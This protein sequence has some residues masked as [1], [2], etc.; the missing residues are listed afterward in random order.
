MQVEANFL[1]QTSKTSNLSGL[2]KEAF[3]WARLFDRRYI[4]RTMVGIMVMFFQRTLCFLFS[5]LHCPQIFVSSEW[6]GINAFIYYGPMLMRDLGL[7]GDS[8]NLLVS[9][10]VNIVQ[11]LS[12]LPVILYIDQY[13]N[14]QTCGMALLIRR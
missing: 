6:S 10:G 3:A 2:R 1:Q 13:G 7:T 12:V 9:G 4:D 11:F 14:V 8:I 5:C